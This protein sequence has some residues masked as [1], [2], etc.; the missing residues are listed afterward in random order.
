MSAAAA[1]ALATASLHAD[2]QRYELV[3]ARFVSKSGALF[4]SIRP[5]R[6]QRSLAIRITKPDLPYITREVRKLEVDDGKES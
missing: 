1:P 5:V 2:L 4:W 6:P 3:P